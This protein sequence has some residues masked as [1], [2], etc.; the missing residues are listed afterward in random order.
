Y[1]SFGISPSIRTSASFVAYPKAFPC[2]GFPVCGSIPLEISII[3]FGS[4]LSVLIAI[5]VD[6]LD[7]A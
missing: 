2:K 4:I 1:A 3:F 5:M 6:L 7:F